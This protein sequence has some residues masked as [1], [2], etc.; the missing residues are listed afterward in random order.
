[1]TQKRHRERRIPSDVQARI[2][3]S[4]AGKKSAAEIHRRLVDEFGDTNQVPSVRTVQDVARELRAPKKFVPWSFAMSSPEDAALILPVYAAVTE[5]TIEEYPTLDESEAE[6]IVSIC[7][8][9]PDLPAYATY[10]VAW[11]YL[12][13]QRRD[14]PTEDLDLLLAFAPW[15][16]PRALASYRAIAEYRP[17]GIGCAPFSWAHE[18]NYPK[19]LE[20]LGFDQSLVDAAN[21]DYQRLV[22]LQA[23][24]DT[25]GRDRKKDKGRT[26]GKS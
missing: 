14:R 18:P 3:E 2:H 9:V 15:R 23:T 12:V 21:G 7:K 20:R 5:R 16:G 4:A 17:A 11:A 8:V 13:R 24:L 10:E 22:G 25:R 1:M 26:G 6:W 19:M